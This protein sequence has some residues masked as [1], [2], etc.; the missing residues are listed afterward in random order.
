VK[1]RRG[2]QKGAELVEMA[3][4]LP[5]LLMLLLGIIAFG[6]AYDVYQT[7]TRAAREGARQ[8][9]LTGCATCANPTTIPPSATIQS[10]YVNPAMQAANLDPTNSVYTSTYKEQYV[11][12][13]PNDP[14]PYICGI[15]ISFKY[16]YTL[17]LPFTSLN[18][19]TL[20]I[21]TAVQMR[22]ENQ[23]TPCPTGLV[24]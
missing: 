19:T 2:G 6:R 22:L 4:V 12:L 5:I 9:V 8:A 10:S 1:A 13:D 21:P 16:P 23:P 14:T 7:I 18:F 3:L 11:T 15:Q 20:N 24:P 17:T